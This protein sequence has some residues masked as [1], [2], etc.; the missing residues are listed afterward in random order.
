MSQSTT[1]ICRDA[2]PWYIVSSVPAL[3]WRELTAE[4]APAKLSMARKGCILEAGQHRALR[5]ARGET[6]ARSQ[7]R[8][9]RPQYLSYESTPFVDQNRV[10]KDL[11]G[12]S[13][14]S[15]S[16][17]ARV[18]RKEFRCM[19]VRPGSFGPPAWNGADTLR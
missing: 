4:L 13:Q 7:V 16:S 19:T 8:S 17:N 14:Y 18:Y 5:R 11:T 2:Q 6:S 12:V 15:T 3:W 1:P 9:S 10:P